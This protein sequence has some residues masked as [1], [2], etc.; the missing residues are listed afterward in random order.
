M[1]RDCY[2]VRDLLALCREDLVSGETRTFVKE[3]LARCP[4]CRAEWEALDGPAL[5]PLEGEE[6]ENGQPFRAFAARWARRRRAVAAALAALALLAAL[7]GGCLASYLVFDTPN[8]CAAAAG[9]AR[10]L[11]TDTETV[12][13]RQQPRV[14]LAKPDGSLLETYM[15]ERGFTELEEE[16]MGALRV[17]TNGETREAV[18]CS[19]NRYWCLWSW[20]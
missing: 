20:R 3:H 4:A 14:V 10:V 12:T 11:W 5:P 16:R 17:F 9:A 8:L 15:A 6:P 13:L 19:Q 1:T 7:L 2:I 18:L